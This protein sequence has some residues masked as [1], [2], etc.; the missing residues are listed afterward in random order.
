MDDQESQRE[1]QLILEILDSMY[2]SEQSLHNLFRFLNAPTRNIAVLNSQRIQERT[3]ALLNR[4]ITM[5][6][7]T[8]VVMSVPLTLNGG[9][10]N[11]FWD[12]EVVRPTRQQIEGAVTRLATNVPEGN[13]AICQEAVGNGAT[14]IRHCNHAFHGNCINEWFEMN[15][16]C[17]VCRYDIRN[18][19]P[20]QNPPP[21][22]IYQSE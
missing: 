10:N 2:E 6:I 8:R 5:N 17:P 20:V 12:P 21:S 7:P 18:Y 19:V 13:C 22:P 14:V 1:R 3:L 15:P 11:G 9:A 4:I 16:R